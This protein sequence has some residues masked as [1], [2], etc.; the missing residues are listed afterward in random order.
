MSL[1]YRCDVNMPEMITKRDPAVKGDGTPDRNALLWAY[2]ACDSQSRIPSLHWM[3]PNTSAVVVK[4]KLETGLVTEDYAFPI[5]SFTLIEPALLR[6]DL[7]VYKRERKRAI[8][9]GG[10]KR[11]EAQ[12]KKGKLTARER[13]QLLMDVGTFCGV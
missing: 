1:K 8:L 2:I 6:L 10:D 12:H 5:S 7:L 13:I 9:G 3:S 4:T 11:I